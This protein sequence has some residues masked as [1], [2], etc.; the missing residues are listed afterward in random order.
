MNDVEVTTPS[1][2][3]DT[4]TGTGVQP[5]QKF[6]T[7]S[8]QYPVILEIGS[9]VVADP[10]FGYEPGDTISITPDNGAVLE[11]TIEGGSVTGVKVLKPGIGFND[12]PTIEVV[13]D[14]G[15]NAEFKPVFRVVD[16]ETVEDLPVGAQIVQVIDCVGKV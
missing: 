6:P 7:T 3:D 4:D 5:T 1:I 13:S 11:P 16:P 14:N 15:Y 10:G 9:V 2:Y 12:I 8:D